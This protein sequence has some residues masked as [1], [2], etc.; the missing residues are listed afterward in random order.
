MKVPKALE[1]ATGEVLGEGA[2]RSWLKRTL[3]TKDLREAKVRAKPVLMDFDRTLSAARVRV[4]AVP[5]R[6]S[7]S[8]SEVKRVADYHYAAVL[9]RDD[10]LRLAGAGERDPDVEMSERE[11]F[12]FAGLG[13]VRERRL[14]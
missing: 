6:T 12:V 3:G 2:P 11:L 5:L 1:A 8:A 4:A 10:D 9:A 7:L 14:C 13:N